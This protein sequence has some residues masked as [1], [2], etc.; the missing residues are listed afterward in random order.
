M[1]LGLLRHPASVTRPARAN[2]A[3]PAQQTFARSAAGSHFQRDFSATPVHLS[4]SVEQKL[5]RT[6][7]TE[8]PSA[9]AGNQQC[10]FQ[11]EVAGVMYCFNVVPETKP[12]RY[13]LMAAAPDKYGKYTV[14]YSKLIGVEITGGKH[15]IVDPV[16]TI[17]MTGF[18]GKSLEPVSI[19]VDPLLLTSAWDASETAGD[20]QSPWDFIVLVVHDDLDKAPL[21][22]QI[23][24]WMGD[25]SKPQS[26]KERIAWFDVKRSEVKKLRGKN[27]T[28]QQDTTT[29]I[30]TLTP[31]DVMALVAEKTP[32]KT[33]TSGFQSSYVAEA[34][35]NPVAIDVAGETKKVP[36]DVAAGQ[37]VPGRKT[38]RRSLDVPP[39]PFEIEA[40]FREGESAIPKGLVG[41]SATAFIEQLRLVLLFLSDMPAL[42][43]K[44]YGDTDTVGTK[45]D[46]QALSEKRASKVGQYL[47]DQSKWLGIP[48]ALP[49]QRIVATIGRGQDEAEKDLK[50]R[51]PSNWKTL[52][53][54]ETDEGVRFRRIVIEY[55]AL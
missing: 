20:H 25:P 10:T 31:V 8:D 17:E 23:V 4:R 12:G 49:A 40:N 36:F 44:I 30:E 11:L 33:S 43:I 2:T 41:D 22:V 54:K 32:T 34:V 50:A 7:E 39:P 15:T 16:G 27:S 55:V 19:F 3:Q 46:N 28:N 45:D 51:H 6:P 5:D 14:I 35:K 18:K 21:P 24:Y 53:G 9:A 42:G 1:K 52:I 29:K 38:Y 26:S 48:P 37:P 13:K 47:Q